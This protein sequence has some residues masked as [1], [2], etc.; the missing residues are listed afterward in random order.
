MSGLLIDRRNV[1]VEL[2]L[3]LLAAL[4][5]TGSPGPAILAIAGTS[6]TSGRSAGLAVA[7]GVTTGSWMWSAMAAFGLGAIMLSHVWLFETIRIA[8]AG[9]LL[10]LAFKSARAALRPGSM[11]ITGRHIPSLRRAYGS[12]L[13]LHLTN[14]KAILF[15]GS[16]FSLGVPPGA[17]WEHLAVIIAAVGIQSALVFHGYALLFSNPRMIS[18]YSRFHR[19]FEAVFACVF[20][21]AGLKI[22]TARL[23]G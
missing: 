4:V 20:G 3:I 17:T 23:D 1:V 6:M 21:A 16:L 12:G 8:G 15:F 14:P 11:A 7:S 5:A 22:L 10:F 18:A 9:Y 19:W 2:P 13:A